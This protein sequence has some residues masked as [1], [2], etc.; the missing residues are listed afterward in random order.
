MTFYEKQFR[1]M[2]GEECPLT[3]I[4]FVGRTMIGRLGDD[5]LAKIDFKTDGTKDEYPALRLRVINR[6]DGEVD[7]QMFG[8]SDIIGKKVTNAGQISV[9]VWEYNGKP[10]WYSY[11]PTGR[12]FEKIGETVSA[13]MSLY[14]QQDMDI[15]MS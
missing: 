14:Q 9:H 1:R 3:N 11:T 2:F 5:L 6:T 8:F 10:D 12:D 13:Y 7:C 4:V 15:D